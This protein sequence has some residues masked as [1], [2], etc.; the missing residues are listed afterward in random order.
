MPAT[1]MPQMDLARSR[2]NRREH[3]LSGGLAPGSA[4]QACAESG[5]EVVHGHLPLGGENEVER[6]GMRGAGDSKVDCFGASTFGGAK[7]RRRG[8]AGDAPFSRG[9]VD[10]VDESKGDVRRDFEYLRSG[11]A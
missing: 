6:P 11:D 4:R 9:L 7:A 8:K 1:R 10:Q 2:P 5:V 3:S